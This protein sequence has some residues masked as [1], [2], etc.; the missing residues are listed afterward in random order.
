MRG[1][2]PVMR[3]PGIDTIAR[4]LR[5]AAAVIED[6]ALEAFRQQRYAGW[7]GDQGRAIHAPDA[8]LASVAEIAIQANRTPE[9]KSGRQ[10][11]LENLVN[12]F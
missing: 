11:W 7:Q 3:S 1:R 9:P 4:A 8:T 10:E 2:G 6:G 12:R 5:R